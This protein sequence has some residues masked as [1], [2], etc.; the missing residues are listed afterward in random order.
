[1]PFRTLVLVLLAMSLEG[2]QQT[3]GLRSQQAA[4]EDV[5]AEQ[6]DSDSPSLKVAVWTINLGSYDEKEPY[7]CV[8]IFGDEH[9]PV[10]LNG[11]LLQF[12]CHF[13]TDSSDMAEKV[14][15]LGWK[16]VLV[17]PKHH[18][19]H[20]MHLQRQLKVYGDLLKL[21]EG[22]YDYS[23]YHDANMWP[24]VA[25]GPKPATEL[26]ADAL[27]PLEMDPNLDIV[28]FHH[29]H[30]STVSEEREEVGRLGLCTP[31][32]LQENQALYHSVPDLTQGL[33]ESSVFIRRATFSPT[34]TNG[35]KRWYET[36][37]HIGCYRDQIAFDYAMWKE[38]VQFKLVKFDNR[39]WRRVAG[40]HKD[41]NSLRFSVGTSQQ[42]APEQQEAS[43]QHEVPQQDSA[44][45]QAAAA[46]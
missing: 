22:G 35:L 17:H 44:P 5:E 40:E 8:R 13:I 4:Q 42:E 21:D 37:D 18:E 32:E 46:A 7:K 33:L 30:R 27:K 20:L 29:P 16:P 24:K 23:I 31:A 14:A 36:M 6:S 1:M 2:L 39:P 34:L 26:I 10:K 9:H 12:T 38:G 43:K 15:P 41:P 45:V 3:A 28:S 25:E 11:K 19:E